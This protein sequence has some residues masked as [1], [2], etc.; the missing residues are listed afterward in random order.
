MSPKSIRNA[1]RLYL[2][3]SIGASIALIV[4]AYSLL[5]M[6]LGYLSICN[7][8]L[9]GILVF[10]Y[11]KFDGIL[12]ELYALAVKREQRDTQA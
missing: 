8:L 2:L 4:A 5:S 12:K 3:M 9:V 10:A 7:L 11:F 6:G 1:R